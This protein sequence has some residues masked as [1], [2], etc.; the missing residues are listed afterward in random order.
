MP[1]RKKSRRPSIAQ[2]VNWYAGEEFDA[3][4]ELTKKITK[5]ARRG[6]LNKEEFVEICWWKSPRAGPRVAANHGGRINAV[7]RRVLLAETNR[8][9]MEY[10]LELE[11]VGIPMAS[12]VLTVVNPACNGVIDIRVWKALRYLGKVSGNP[13]GVGFTINQWLAFVSELETVA[14]QLGR[15]ARDVERALF[16]YHKRKLQTGRLYTR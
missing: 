6:H 10:L 9:R 7:T 8:E 16:R 12:A 13:N 5:A 3:F 15:T 1:N 14:E 4:V 11:G 2:V